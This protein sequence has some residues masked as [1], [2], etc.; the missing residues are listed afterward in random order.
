[1][2]K[3]K[4][5]G[6]YNNVGKMYYKALSFIRSKQVVTRSMVEKFYKDAGKSDSSAIASATVLLSPRKEDSLRGKFGNC[7]GN[8]SAD[9]VHY[10]MIVLNHKKGEEKKFRFHL[11]T[12]DEVTARTAI[13]EKRGN[14]RKAKEAKEA[15]VEKVA[16][17]VKQVKTTAATSKKEKVVKTAKKVAKKTAKKVAVE[18]AAPVAVVETVATVEVASVIPEAAVEIVEVASVI[19]ET[20]AV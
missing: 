18:V 8:F 9:G 1:M 5:A 2:S 11:A 4:N 20:P 15:K 6:A 14:G 16:K 19:P 17:E 12:A 13:A 3:I 7:L 10:Y